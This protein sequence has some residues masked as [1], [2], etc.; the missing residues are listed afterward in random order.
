MM[1]TKKNQGRAKRDRIAIALMS[2]EEPYFKSPW[3]FVNF[4]D[5]CDGHLIFTFS[6]VLAI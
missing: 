3:H 1:K 6:Q 4:S 2:V 5:A